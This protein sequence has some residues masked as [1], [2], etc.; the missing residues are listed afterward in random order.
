MNIKKLIILISLFLSVNIANA[1]IIY[2][3]TD[4]NIVGITD[5]NF[6]AALGPIRGY[7]Q[8]DVVLTGTSIILGK[9]FEQQEHGTACYVEAGDL[10]AEDYTYNG[11]E[12]HA[13]VSFIGV[14][15]RVHFG[16]KSQNFIRPIAGLNAVFGNSDIPSLN[17][18]YDFDLPSIAL[19]VEIIPFNNLSDRFEVIKDWSYLIIMDYADNDGG[20]YKR[21][22]HNVTGYF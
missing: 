10:D 1:E 13:D 8:D 14:G 2:G 18:N 19:G 7:P 12:H 3:V 6:E 5:N 9:M 11:Q 21:L 22:Q 15:C 16:N 17:L 4:K 20:K